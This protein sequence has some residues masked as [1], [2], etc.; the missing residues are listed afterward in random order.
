MARVNQAGAIVFR[1]EGGTFRILLVTAKR[2]PDQ[3][4]FPKGHVE[5]GESAEAA[6]LRE[7]HE[8]SGVRGTIISQAGSLSYDLAGDLYL[9]QYFLVEAHDQG[10]ESEGRRLAWCDYDD[11]LRRLTFDDARDL[12]TTVRP[13]IDRVIASRPSGSAQEKTA[14]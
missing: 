10:Q 13:V 12:L 7:A 5:P 14:R 3:W 1:T 11:A 9:V 4:I 2:N 6:A 8:E